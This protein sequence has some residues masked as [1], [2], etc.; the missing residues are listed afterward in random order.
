MSVRHESCGISRNKYIFFQFPISLSPHHSQLSNK[1]LVAHAE[2]LLANKASE[3]EFITKKLEHIDVIAASLNE[4][5]SDLKSGGSGASVG[6]GGSGLTEY[7][8]SFLKELTNETRD[9]IQDMRLEVLTA[10]DK[11]ESLESKFDLRR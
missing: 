11:S 10:S 2:Q 7:D 1:N 9:A 8:R 6:S 3:S 4:I 5:K